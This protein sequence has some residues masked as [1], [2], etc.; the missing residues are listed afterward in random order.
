M[1]QRQLSSAHQTESI[2]FRR[3][4]VKGISSVGI[5]RNVAEKYQAGYFFYYQALPFVLKREKI[6]LRPFFFFFF[7]LR[8]G[9]RSFSV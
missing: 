8:G 2:Y 1:T 6:S 4:G 9:K 7:A 3:L 5:F